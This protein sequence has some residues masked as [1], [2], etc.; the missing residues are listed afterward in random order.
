MSGKIA[1]NVTKIRSFSSIPAAWTFSGS[2]YVATELDQHIR[3]LATAWAG[4]GDEPWIDL[5]SNQVKKII[6]DQLCPVVRDT[7]G[8]L[9]PP[10]GGTVID[11]SVD[12]LLAT[13]TRP[14]GGFLVRV[15]PDT[16]TMVP[17]APMVAMGY[18]HEYATVAQGLLSHHLAADPSLHEAKVLAHRTVTAVCEV[19]SGG[20]GPPVQLATVT[21]TGVSILDVDDVDAISLAVDRWKNLEQESLIALRDGEPA[22]EA[23]HDLPGTTV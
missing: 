13:W 14:S 9:T 3:G 17:D 23:R 4:P 5:D 18:G 11:H 19:S 20:V 16:A 8:R 1:S 15:Y 2:T 22:R 7:Y 12:L 10:P 21:Q 6:E